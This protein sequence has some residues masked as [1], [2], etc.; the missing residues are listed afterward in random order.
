M[1]GYGNVAMQPLFEHRRLYGGIQT[2]VLELE[3]DGVPLIFFHGYGDSADCWR[4]MLKLLGE[5]GRRAIAVDVRG[6]AHADRLS[7]ERPILPQL[8]EYG[9]AVVRAVAREEGQSP[10]VIG[11][12]LGGLLSLR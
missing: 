12:S 7:S 8:D 9:A 6:F 11:N 4:L 10:Y 1:L 3:G 5:R 2:R